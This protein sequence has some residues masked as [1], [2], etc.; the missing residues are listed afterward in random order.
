MAQTI[1]LVR[2]QAQRFH[3]NS[4]A[5]QL[6]VALERT[7]TSTGY[8]V[9]LWGT[10]AT[11]SPFKVS[12]DGI[13]QQVALPSSNTPEVDTNCLFWYSAGLDTSMHTVV[14]TNTATTGLGITGFSVSEYINTDK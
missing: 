6:F 3:S 11:E 7:N 14:V 9:Q 5:S 10:D 4:K 12:I 8:A 1:V 13:S 2:L